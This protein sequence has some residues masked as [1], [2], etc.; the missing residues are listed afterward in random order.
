ML[1]KKMVFLLLNLHIFLRSRLG[2]LQPLSSF[3]IQSCLIPYYW[4]FIPILSELLLSLMWHLGSLYIK[5]PLLSLLWKFLVVQ[6]L[7]DAFVFNTLLCNHSLNHGL[8]LSLIFFVHHHHL[9]LW[10]AQCYLHHLLRISHGLDWEIDKFLLWNS[11]IFILLRLKIFL[12]LRLTFSIIGLFFLQ[13]TLL[14][15]NLFLLLLLLSLFHHPLWRKYI[16]NLLMT[17]LTLILHKSFYLESTTL[18]FNISFNKTS[19]DFV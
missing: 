5:L 8:F 13:M 10:Q 16:I 15:K 3:G 17:S 6:D 19:N 9:P 4:I 11:F 18:Q 1:M 2:F 7:I 14:Y 12:R